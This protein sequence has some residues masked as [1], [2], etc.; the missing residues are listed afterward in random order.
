[1]LVGR[2]VKPHA[3]RGEVLIKVFTDNPHRFDP[4]SWLLAGKQAESTRPVQVLSSRMIHDKLLVHFEGCPDTNCA[5]TLRDQLLFVAEQELEE[6]GE[7]QFW[8]RDLIGLQVLHRDGAV[9]GEIAGV[10]EGAAQDL[11]SIRTP[12]GGE[13]LFP[14][15]RQL[16]VSVDLPT[17]KA[18][19]D[20]PEGLF[21]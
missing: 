3:L 21:E 9:L 20:P 13:V 4:G 5:E 6:L 18:V 17:R 16:V 10:L 7:G 1:M 12:G 19:I 15:A 2:V 14:A 8:E 11:W